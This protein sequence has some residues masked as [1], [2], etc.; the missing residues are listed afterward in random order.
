MTI[1]NYSIIAA[2]PTA[3]ALL[4][5]AVVLKKDQETLIAMHARLGA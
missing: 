2:N 3:M 5:Q 1:L 4:L